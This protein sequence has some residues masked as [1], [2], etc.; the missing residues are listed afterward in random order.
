V[1]LQWPA[2]ARYKK[3]MFSSANR[4]CF[5]V[6][7][8]VLP[9]LV[10]CNAK[11]S[12]KPKTEESAEGA[13]KQGAPASTESSSEAASSEK[14][15]PM[16][17]PNAIP[18]PEDVAAAP[19]AAETSP[20]GLASLRLSEGSGEKSPGPEDMV[21]VHYTGWTK[22]GKMFDSSVSRGKPANF[23]LNQVI[24]GWTEGLQLMKAGEKRRFWIPGKLAYGETPRRP[25]APAGQLTFDVE[26]LEFFSPPKAQTGPIPAPKD[27]KK[28]GKS[29]KHTESGLAYRVLTEG[30]GDKHPG[31]SSQVLV[32]YTGWRSE[33]GEMFDSSLTRGRFATFPLNRVIRGWTEGLQL[34]VEGE[35]A[36]FWIPGELAY[37][38]TP[39]RPGAPAGQ[40]VF[41]VELHKILD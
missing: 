1:A 14:E 6:V 15:G 19:E 34:M 4:I 40:L 17:D 10:A 37:G 22:D 28:P 2:G 36:R 27:V 11:K 32:S 23:P 26:L 5:V 41:D 38:D 20:T 35:K 12:S 24:P 21:V 33:T 31:P 25:G 7:A 3:S 8:A 29:A 39:A 16:N 30:K 13:A 18:P 9:T